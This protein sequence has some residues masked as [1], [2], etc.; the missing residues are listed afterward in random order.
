M[1]VLFEL[2]HDRD[3]LR[4]T[5]ESTNFI[6]CGKLYEF[7]FDKSYLA[8]DNMHTQRSYKII[9]R[10]HFQLIIY[11]IMEIV[12]GV[13][14]KYNFENMVTSGYLCFSQS[15]IS[16]VYNKQIITSFNMHDV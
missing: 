3:L 12:L 8:D 1:L 16:K 15:I 6:I 11:P 10:L 4:N 13:P 7:C 9:R 2:K 5:S 14:G